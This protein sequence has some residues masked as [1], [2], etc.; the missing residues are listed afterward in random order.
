MRYSCDKKKGECKK[1]NNATSTRHIQYRNKYQF[2]M[3][4]QQ[5]APLWICVDLCDHTSAAYSETDDIFLGKQSSVR[6]I[7]YYRYSDDSGENWNHFND[8]FIPTTILFPDNPHQDF[9][10]FGAMMMIFL[11]LRVARTNFFRVFRTRLCDSDSWMKLHM[12]YIPTYENTREIFW[13]NEFFPLK[14][15][16]LYVLC[17]LQISM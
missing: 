2:S 12:C 3:Q 17:L 15:L 4:R 7:M 6:E 8:C 13:I 14:G 16:L 10:Q 11:H 1:N 5:Q 9:H